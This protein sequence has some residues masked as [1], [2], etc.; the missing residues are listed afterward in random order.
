MSLLSKLESHLGLTRGDVTVTLF[1]AT[2]TLGGFIYL[3]FFDT[4]SPR[5]Q[6]DELMALSMRHDSIVA[7][8]GRIRQEAVAKMARADSASA[9]DT[10]DTWKPLTA[11]D[12]AADEAVEKAARPATGGGKK[13]LAGPVNL[14]TARKPELVM[15]PGVGEKTA[16]AI[17][18]RRAHVPFRRIEDIMDVKGIGQKKFEKM[19]PFLRIR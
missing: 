13:V 12:A 19:K 10:V 18:E 4:R 7:A 1:I 15:L 3:T 8:R 9:A 2:I 5:V 14:N 17:I 6:H 16:D 11:D